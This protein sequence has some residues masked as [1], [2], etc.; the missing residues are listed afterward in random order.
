MYLLLLKMDMPIYLIEN[1]IVFWWKWHLKLV[2]QT[3][4]AHW[5][6]T[7]G[8]GEKCQRSSYTWICSCCLHLSPDTCFLALPPV[9]LKENMLQS[10]LENCI[11]FYYIFKK[12]ITFS[13]LLLLTSPLL[14]SSSSLFLILQDTVVF[15]EGQKWKE[16]PGALT[17]LDTAGNSQFSQSF[18]K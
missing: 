8:R 9:P 13:A 18:F 17:S 6:L 14:Y 15:P 16:T 12:G 5:N 4:C 7:D 3:Q 1:M 10:M 11:I 2:S